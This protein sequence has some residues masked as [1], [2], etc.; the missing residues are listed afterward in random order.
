MLLDGSVVSHSTN[1]NQV[2]TNNCNFYCV[3]F[4]KIKRQI[5]KTWY[6]DSNFSR[7]LLWRT[8]SSDSVA[9]LAFGVSQEI[10]FQVFR[11]S[12]ATLNEIISSSLETKENNEKI[13]FAVTDQ[14]LNIS[15]FKI[16]W[17]SQSYIHSLYQQKY[18]C[19]KSLWDG[20]STL[21]LKCLKN[22]K[23]IMVFWKNGGWKFFY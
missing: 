17:H 21:S 20:L 23:D 16:C 11:N 5:K 9:I 15:W 10:F 22:C 12:L 19:W 7:Y 3:I 4:W 14:G 13:Y 2:N 8:K 1:L 18:L 6:L